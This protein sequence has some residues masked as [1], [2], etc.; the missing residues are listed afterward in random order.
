MN[1]HQQHEVNI[2][3]DNIGA[4]KGIIRTFELVLLREPPV[5]LVPDISESIKRA[6]RIIE[7][8]QHR[9]NLIE[10]GG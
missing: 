5:W 6:E 10:Q 1:R 4:A 7:R 3:L 2:S 8:E 9:I